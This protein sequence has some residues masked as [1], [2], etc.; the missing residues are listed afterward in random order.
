MTTSFAPALT[1][2]KDWLRFHIGDIG[3]DGWYLQDETIT[4]LITEYGLNT[5]V[6]RAIYFI[7]TQLS[8]PNFRL[9]W[10][11]VDNASAID[12]FMKL[13]KIKALELGV[14]LSNVTASAEISLPYRADSY[15][16]SSESTY[17]GAP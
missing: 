2:E 12:G 5:A 15:Q 3:P 14:S 13:L 1:T 10:M 11:S 17:D 9:D 8:Q 7:I 16:D 4:A 6:I